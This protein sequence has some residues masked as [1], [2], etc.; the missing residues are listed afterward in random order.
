MWWVSLPPRMPI[1]ASEYYWA[2]GCEEL[3][4]IVVHE[5][6]WVV[7]TFKQESANL[8]CINISFRVVSIDKFL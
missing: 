7:I 5:C 8:S 4:T 3:V 2:S 1:D 6:G